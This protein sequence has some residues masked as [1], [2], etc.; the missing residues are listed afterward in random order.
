[1]AH[2]LDKQH[3]ARVVKMAYGTNGLNI[4]HMAHSL[5]MR[6]VAHSIKV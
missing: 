6:H 3:V 1:M 4:R 2:S 5:K